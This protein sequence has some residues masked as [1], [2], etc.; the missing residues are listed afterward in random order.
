MHYT[1]AIYSLFFTLT[2]IY[3]EY[4]QYNALNFVCSRQLLAVKVNVAKFT[5]A[6]VSIAFLTSCLTKGE[7]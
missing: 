7:R 2:P 1:D 6:S 3:S 5:S 4:V